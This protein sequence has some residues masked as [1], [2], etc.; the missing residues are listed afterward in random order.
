MNAEKISIPIN[1]YGKTPIFLV[2]LSALESLATTIKEM[3]LKPDK[4]A[5]V[6]IGELSQFVS[7]KFVYPYN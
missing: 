6:C 7:P 5:N 3:M 1:K 4:R 2:P